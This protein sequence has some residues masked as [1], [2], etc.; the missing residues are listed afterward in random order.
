MVKPILLEVHVRHPDLSVDG[1]RLEDGEELNREFPETFRIP[2]RAVREALQPGDFAK[3]V[4]AFAVE[5]DDGENLQ[6]VDRMWVVV[7][8]RSAG[9]YLGQLDNEPT[10]IC[11]ND[12][13]WLGAELPFEPRHV[14][15][16]EHGNDASVA[17]AKAPPAIPWAR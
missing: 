5:G 10:A 9:G 1:W 4:F 6:E 14:I 12:A 15:D 17:L 13:F 11:E 3:L 7:R 2:G 8:E 16:V